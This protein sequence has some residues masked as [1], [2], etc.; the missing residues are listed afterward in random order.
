MTEDIYHLVHVN[1]AEGRGAMDDPIMKGF[2]DRIEEID[3]IAHKWPGFISQPTPPDEGSI[4]PENILVNV[5]IW[6][7]VEKL[8]EFTYESRHA[9][10]LGMRADWFHQSDLP[11]Y[12]LYWAPAPELPTEGEIKRRF[13]YLHQHGA[14]PFAFNFAKTFTVKEMLNYSGQVEEK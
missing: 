11:N 12:V 2:V 7:T 4:Y 10:V 3:G 14:T 5:S 1:I 13:D 9:E 6:E 8:R